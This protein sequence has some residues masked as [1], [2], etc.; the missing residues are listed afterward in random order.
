M[1]TFQIP[2]ALLLLVLAALPAHA[3][4]SRLAVQALHCS[5]IFAVFA[6]THADDPALARKFGRG[7]EI[8]SEVYAKE[9]GGVSEAAMQEVAARRATLLQ[10]F[11]GRL[12]ERASYLREDG[13]VCGAWAEGFFAQG[14][15]WSYVPVYPKVIGAGVRADYQ[16]IAAD[17][18]GRWGR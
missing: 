17:A 8:F 2:T 7:V 18:F 6:D 3:Q 9:R 13:V 14:A 16:K 4:E 1:K 5:A 12:D 11:R 10:E 15:Q